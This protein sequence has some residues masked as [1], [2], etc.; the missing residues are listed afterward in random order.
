M[1]DIDFHR[2]MLPLLIAGFKK[3]LALATCFF[4]AVLSGQSWN[5]STWQRVAAVLEQ[6]GQK[7][8]S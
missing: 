8:R 3:H 5:E 1:A 4:L 7:R 6:L 2:L